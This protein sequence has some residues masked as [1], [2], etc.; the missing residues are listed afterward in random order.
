MWGH[1]PSTAEPQP[2]GRTQGLRWHPP[3][4]VAFLL[5][6]WGH[7][8]TMWLNSPSFCKSHCNLNSPEEFICE[9]NQ[10]FFLCHNYSSPNN[11]ISKF[12]YLTGWIF[13]SVSTAPRA[14]RTSSQ[15]GFFSESKRKHVTVQGLGAARTMQLQEAK[16]APEKRAHSPGSR[17]VFL[18]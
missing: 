10:S 5:C 9:T 6:A 16:R 18:F 15:K 12:T 8:P 7:S 4:P 11:L 2:V 13:I 3:C 14:P 1:N 17:W